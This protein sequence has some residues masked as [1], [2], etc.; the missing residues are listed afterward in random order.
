MEPLCRV[1]E[2]GRLLTL[3]TVKDALRRGKNPTRVLRREIHSPGSDLV[4]YVYDFLYFTV[5]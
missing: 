1:G 5:V 3:A 4:F 2:A